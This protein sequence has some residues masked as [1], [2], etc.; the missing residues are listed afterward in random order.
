MDE[1]L[2][3]ALALSLSLNSQEPSGRDAEP[4]WSSSSQNPL[5]GNLVGV[6]SKMLCEFKTNGKI[7]QVRN[8]WS[9]FMDLNQLVH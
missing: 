5:S 1:D 8:G 6:E 2:Q 4:V 7:V 3:L 9:S